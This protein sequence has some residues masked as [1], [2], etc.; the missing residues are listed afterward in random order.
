MEDQRRRRLR[1]GK[2]ISM[3]KVRSIQ[4]HLKEIS[5]GWAWIYEKERLICHVEKA[6]KKEAKVKGVKVEKIYEL[7]RGGIYI[8]LYRKGTV[9]LS[10]WNWMTKTNERLS[11]EH[12]IKIYWFGVR[13]MD[14]IK[15]IPTKE[16]TMPCKGGKKG[17]KGRK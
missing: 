10:E 12:K 11:R 2:S 17:R 1:N 4:V 3:Q 7:K 13:E 16:I 15:F 6:G 14:D 5:L 9:S 8:M